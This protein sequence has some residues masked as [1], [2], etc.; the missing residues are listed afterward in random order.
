MTSATVL[1]R[2]LF[3]TALC[4]GLPAAA[5]QFAAGDQLVA[6]IQARWAEIKYREA[7]KTHAEAYERLAERAREIAASHP[8]EAAALIW[9]GI[10]LSSEA[11]ARGGLGALSL[12]KQARALLEESLKLD[13]RALDGSAYTSLATLY[14]KVPGWPLGFGDKARAE[15]L[16]RK[17]LEIN[18]SGIDPNYFYGEYLVDSGRV[19]E[20]RVFLERALQAPSRPGRELADAGRREEV[21]VLLDRIAEEGS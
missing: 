8:N 11:G 13:E 21:R 16:F 6:P 5:Q 2:I 18:P 1:R 4:L 9:E 15:A 7:V 10:V 3:T 17:S 14:A 20:G 19:A 12:V